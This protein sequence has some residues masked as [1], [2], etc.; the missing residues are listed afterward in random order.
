M[1]LPSR[2]APPIDTKPR[3]SQPHPPRPG[4]THHAP[5]PPCSRL[6]RRVGAGE[7]LAGAMGAGAVVPAAAQLPRC[8]PHQLWESVCQG[9]SGPQPPPPCPSRPPGCNGGR[10]HC[11]R[12]AL[13]C[14]HSVV[15]QQTRAPAR[16]RSLR[17]PPAAGPRSSPAVGLEVEP[18]P[19]G[20]WLPVPPPAAPAPRSTPAGMS[21]S[22]TGNSPRGGGDHQD[23]QSRR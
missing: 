18:G 22:Y 20:S 17:R 6:P 10:W 14:S 13:S 8:G 19:P 5:A 1:P 11:Q 15:P 7:G 9:G 3:P 4:P 16:P 21:M 2:D 23:G 12:S